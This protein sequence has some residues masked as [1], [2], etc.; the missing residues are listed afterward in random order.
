MKL[1]ARLVEL[2]RQ[3]WL[4]T[5]DRRHNNSRKTLLPRLCVITSE[6]FSLSRISKSV[7]NVGRKTKTFSKYVIFLLSLEIEMA[8]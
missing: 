2:R 1:E 8:V 6:I 4:P 3:S 5:A 7:F